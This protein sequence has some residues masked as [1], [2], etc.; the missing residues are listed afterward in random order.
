M[1]GR[2]M[3]LTHPGGSIR[4]SIEAMGWTVTECARRLGTPREHLSRLLN[5]RIGI[6]P[7]NGHSLGTYRLEQRQILAAPASLL[8]SRPGAPPSKRSVTGAMPLHYR[9]AERAQ[10]RPGPRATAANGLCCCWRPRPRPAHESPAPAR[11]ASRPPLPP[12]QNN[13]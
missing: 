4:D 6:S 5:G 9:A 11:P 1:T 8:R 12:R 7:A 13:T 10:R 2:E 3:P